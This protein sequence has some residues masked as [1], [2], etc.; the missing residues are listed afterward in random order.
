MFELQSSLQFMA[1]P[2]STTEPE[3]SITM[4]TSWLATLNVAVTDLLELIVTVHVPVPE[5]PDPLHPV[6][7]DPVA[8]VAVRTT[9]SF[10][11]IAFVQVEVQ[12]TPPTSLVTRPDPAIVRDKSTPEIVKDLVIVAAA[13]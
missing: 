5:H 12:S 3:P 10:V 2:E 8:G 13:A 6:K 11:R 4:L 7:V 1:L 9:T